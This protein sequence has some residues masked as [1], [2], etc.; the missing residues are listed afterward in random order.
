MQVC[1]FNL[2]KLLEDSARS[3]SAG[4][5]LNPRWLAP[6]VLMGRPAT[7]ESDVF[8]FGTVLWEL[9]TW[10]LPWEGANLYQLVF[11]VSRG[12]R[13]PIPPPGELPG[14]DQV[15]PPAQCDWGLYS[16]TS[17]NCL[18]HPFYLKCQLGHPQ[19]PLTLRCLPPAN[20]PVQLASYDAY[21]ALIRRCWA[22][23]P[24]E[25]PSF[26]EAITELR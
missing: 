16:S 22:Q 17:L 25:R 9:L 24:S 15:I 7:A 21:T 11:M 2:S 6:E 14:A 8:S 5:M 12:E 18:N 26:A 1:D 20:P 4:G 19:V 3:S 13:L 10:R 23:E